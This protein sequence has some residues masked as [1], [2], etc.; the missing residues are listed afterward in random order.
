MFLFHRKP[1]PPRSVLFVCTANVTRSPVAEILF[2]KL[3][4]SAGE[5][6]KVASAG[7]NGARGMGVNQVI[8]FIMFQRGLSMQH[9]RSQPVKRKLLTRYQWI[10]VME[11]GHRLSI[12]EMDENLKDRV[13]LFRELTNTEPLDHHNMPD[14]TG[15]DV[16]DYRELF[17]IF[18]AEMPVLVKILRDKAYE[19]EMRDSNDD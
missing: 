13:F 18:D 19:F 5:I 16:D 9:H 14:P 17:N 15:R 3:V 1:P 6:W 7:V 2:R 12:L 10:V 11:E 4:G 8:S